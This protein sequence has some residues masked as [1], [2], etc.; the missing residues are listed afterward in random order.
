MRGWVKADRGCRE[1]P[2]EPEKCLTAHR[3]FDLTLTAKWAQLSTVGSLE[4]LFFS[5]HDALCTLHCSLAPAL[6]FLS[7]KSACTGGERR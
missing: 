5:L 2:D 1:D 6:H 3:D 7:R 4:D